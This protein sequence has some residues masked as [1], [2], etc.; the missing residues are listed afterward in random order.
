MQQ[1]MLL[2]LAID[3]GI[4]QILYVFSIGLLALPFLTLLERL[5]WKVYR[6]D[7][8]RQTPSFGDL[9]RQIKEIVQDCV[10]RMTGP[11]LFYYS[12]RRSLQ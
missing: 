2:I 11:D 12:R 9:S 10:T 6:N 3:H 1:Y 5:G 8:F 4:N 7:G